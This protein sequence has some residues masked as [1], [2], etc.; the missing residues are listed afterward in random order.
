VQNPLNGQLDAAR[1]RQTVRQMAAKVGMT[2]PI[3]KRG[4][5]RIRKRVMQLYLS[6]QQDRV[7]KGKW[8]AA[9]IDEDVRRLMGQADY[10]KQGFSSRVTCA[11]AATLSFTDPWAN[12]YTGRLAD[13]IDNP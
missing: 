6:G 1:L 8:Y 4:H 7:F 3:F 11:V 12:Y 13:I 10:D 2:L 9:L 5:R